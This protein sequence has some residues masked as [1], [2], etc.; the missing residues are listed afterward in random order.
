MDLNMD[1]GP[2]LEAA[3]L[4]LAA[5]ISTGGAFAV[6]WMKRRAKAAG[7]EVDDRVRAYLEPIAE[8]GLRAAFR[9]LPHVDASTDEARVVEARDYVKRHAPDALRHFKLTDQALEEYIEA[10]LDR[11]KAT[12]PEP[13]PAQRAVAKPE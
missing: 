11:V 3:V 6:S 7:L 1:P 10:R 9:R 2:L 4:A 8:A 5:I 13:V 12:T